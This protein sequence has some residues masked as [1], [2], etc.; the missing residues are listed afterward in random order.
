VKKIEVSLKSDNNTRYFTSRP[1][2][3]SDHISLISY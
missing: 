3:I 2:Y 1:I